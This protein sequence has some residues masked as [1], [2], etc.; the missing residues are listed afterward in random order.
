MLKNGGVPHY[1]GFLGTGEL[2]VNIGG[3]NKTVTITDRSKSS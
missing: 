2:N 3:T 1:M